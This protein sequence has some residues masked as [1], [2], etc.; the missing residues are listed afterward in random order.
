MTGAKDPDE[1][2]QTYGRDAF[3]KLLDGSEN[4]MEYRL[5]QLR[6]Q[7]NFEEAGDRVSIYRRPRQ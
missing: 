6:N 4:Y 5:M 2:I 7:Y 3:Q 1:F